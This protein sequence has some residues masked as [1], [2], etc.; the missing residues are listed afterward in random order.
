MVSISQI[1]TGISNYVD[2]EALPKM[3]G[4]NKVVFATGVSLILNKLESIL[5]KYRSNE[6]LKAIEVFDAEGNIDID[7]VANEFVKHVP[8]SGLTFDIPII[9]QII[10]YPQDVNSIH[11]YIS[12]A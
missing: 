9:G 11:H 2:N 7:L 12:N 10:I 4:F 8:N 1:K 3:Q 5:D 6:L